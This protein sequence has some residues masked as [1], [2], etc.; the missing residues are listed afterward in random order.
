MGVGVVRGG[1]MREMMEET[2][3]SGRM[4]LRECGTVHTAS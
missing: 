3:E 2:W 4:K 1:E